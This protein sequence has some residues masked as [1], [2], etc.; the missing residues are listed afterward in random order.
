[1]WSLTAPAIIILL[2]S[3]SQTSWASVGRVTEQTG[4][5]EIVRNKKSSPSSVNTAVEMNDTV[6]TARAKARLEFVDKTTV[7][8]TEQSKITI[9]EFVYDPKSGSGKLA[10]KM[11][12]GTARY[13]SGQIA[14]NSPQ[15]VNVTTPTATVAVRGTDF[16]MT[17]D[18]L[19]RSLVMLLPSCDNSGC[20][21]G[22]ILVSNDAGSVLMDTAYQTTIVTSLT[23]A[24]SAPVII[25]IDQSNINNLLIVAPPPEI[26]AENIREK[27]NQL[28]T[29]LDVNFLNKDLLKF[30]ELDQDQLK[31]FAELDVNFLEVNLLVNMLDLSNQQLAANQEAM[32]A[33]KTM[34]PNYNA[35][36]GL[37]Y[38]LS[39]NESS[40]VLRKQAA[41]LAQITVDL[42]ADL[43][44]NIAQDGAPLPQQVNRGGTTT[45]TIIQR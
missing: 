28:R 42:E 16:S 12:Q 44:L 37:T 32:L 41:H 22:A 19:G 4:P 39:E 30:D 1:V 8:I 14:K 26:V 2:L 45:I 27:T 43:V 17:V 10:M 5:T 13:A 25:T 38:G 21:T 11:V 24:P 34:L 29:A 23:S 7:N 18:E 15:N 33:E 20:V 35:A 36:S 6:V 9:D 3:F 40:L 31:K